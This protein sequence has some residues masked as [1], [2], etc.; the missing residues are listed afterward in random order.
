MHTNYEV[1]VINYPLMDPRI[2][3]ADYRAYMQL[4]YTSADPWDVPV[5]IHIPFCENLC[6]FCVY[7]RQIP[8]SE[9][10]LDNYVQALKKEI[11]LYAKTPYIRS[12]RP[13]AVFI[14]GGTPTVLSGT[15][16][17]DIIAA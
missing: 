1:A 14:G 13:R 9:K 6:K 15:Q 16:L 4:D 11:S 2:K 17:A 12:L 10:L 8:D 3:P 7:S 5:Y